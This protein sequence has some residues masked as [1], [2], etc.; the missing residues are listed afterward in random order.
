MSYSNKT[1]E[2]YPLSIGKVLSVMAVSLLISVP[3]LAQ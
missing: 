3:A 2:N 1:V